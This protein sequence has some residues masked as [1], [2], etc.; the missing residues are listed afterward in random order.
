MAN[1]DLVNK[2]LSG[3]LAYDYFNNLWVVKK[4]KNGNDVLDKL[5]P[6]VWD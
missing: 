2:D 3:K 6:K 1:K 5:V 4:D